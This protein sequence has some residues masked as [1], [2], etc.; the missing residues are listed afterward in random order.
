MTVDDAR[1]T[2]LQIDNEMRSRYKSLKD[3]VQP[4]LGPFIVVANGP[5][6]GTYWLIENNLVVE[7]SDPID[8]MFQLAKS[9]AHIPLGTFSVLAPYLSD[10]V[11]PHHCKA[12]DIDPHDLAMV[13][14]TGPTS[15]G[16]VQPLQDWGIFIEATRL[17]LADAELPD[18]LY[19]SS[20]RICEAATRF[21]GKTISQSDFSMKDFE[22]FTGGIFPDISTNMYWAAKVQIQAVV[23]LMSRWKRQLGARWRDV[24]VLVYS[25][26]TTS[27][28]NQN[29]IIIRRFLDADR[30]NTHLLDIIAD[31]LPVMDP[32]GVGS[33]NL[34]RIVQD[35]IAAEMIFP[36]SQTTASALKGKED[37]LAQEIL[38]L[39]GDD[40]STEVAAASCPFGHTRN[41][42][43]PAS[44][45]PEVAGYPAETV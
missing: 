30:V 5:D 11:P 13:A 32:V 29:T 4:H 12:G 43:V 38:K 18:D 16:W 28:L 27:V 20:T 10:V 36:T 34:A 40:I 19:A 42:R 35:N 2:I 37:L 17:A 39:L 24:Y 45:E 44:P 26:W 22:E 14:F 21:I 9:I 23:E 8:V 25:M 31:Q 1:K 3:Q 15:T 33:E 41:R 6:G 7:K